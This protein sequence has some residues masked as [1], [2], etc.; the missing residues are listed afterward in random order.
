[1]EKQTKK[2]YLEMVR[3]VALFLVFYTHT[4]LKGMHYYQVSSGAEYWISMA[5]ALLSQISVC[6]FFMISGV[7]LLGKKDS[8]KSL[9]AKRVLR[10][11]VVLAVMV[12]FQQWY[13]SYSLG[14]DF[15]IGDYPKLLYT[16][17]SIIQ[18]WYLY[19]YL[20]FLIVLPMLQRMVSVMEEDLYIYLFVVMVVI[21]GVCP[22]CERFLDWK[23]F[24]VV[25]PFMTNIIFYPLMG[26]YIENVCTKKCERA[27]SK[28]LLILGTIGLFTVNTWLV[29]RGYVN[30]GEINSLTYFT[31]IYTVCV[32]C[33]I[34]KLL[35]N[36]SENAR[37][38]KVISFA[39]SGVFA[40]Y[41]FEPQIRESMM[42][43]YD[44]LEPSISHI[45]ALIMWLVACIIIG[46]TLGGV[47]KKIPIIKKFI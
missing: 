3:I 16:G 15:N 25:V 44:K 32:F 5:L 38:G 26:Y 21:G 12:L 4:G 45:P 46:T 40:A 23:E 9:Y 2:I 35:A 17:G 10:I 43:I 6:L 19:A 33:V 30:T 24:G 20:G 42:V 34:R 18:Q 8:V 28:I 37:V 31:P 13:K 22:L 41:L 36:V 7:T 27:I 11:V 47:L 1:M 14:T 29:K 39:G